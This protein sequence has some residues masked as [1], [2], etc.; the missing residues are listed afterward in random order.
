VWSGGLVELLEDVVGAPADLLGDGEDRDLSAGAPAR[1]LVER[2]VGALAAVA[3]LGGLDE[4]V[5]KLRR[6][7]FGK[8]AAASALS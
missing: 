2:V 8:P 1:A 3:V 6:A 4:A 5:A 7:L